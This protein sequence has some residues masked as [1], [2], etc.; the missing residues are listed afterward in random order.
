MAAVI[1]NDSDLCL[2]IDVVQ[3][4]FKMDVQVL[5]PHNR[6][7]WHLGQVAT[8]QRPIRERVIKACQ[9]PET[10]TDDIGSFKKPTTW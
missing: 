9:F 5:C 7:S 6:M 4:R 3:T 1:S 10:L 8:G 2:P